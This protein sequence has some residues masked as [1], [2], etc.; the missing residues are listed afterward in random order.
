MKHCDDTQGWG[1]TLPLAATAVYLA[2]LLL[3]AL[4]G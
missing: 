1:M 4:A 3:A 2:L